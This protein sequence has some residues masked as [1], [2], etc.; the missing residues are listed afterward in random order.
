MIVLPTIGIYKP[1]N[2]PTSRTTRLVKR[3]A[4]FTILVGI[5]SISL[6]TRVTCLNTR[7]VSFLIYVIDQ[8][9]NE[10]KQKKEKLERTEQ[11][12]KQTNIKYEQTNQK[13][14]QYKKEMK[15]SQ[16]LNK[17]KLKINDTQNPF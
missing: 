9:F 6:V 11:E 3:F 16:R 17:Q 13:C 8:L 2:L 5:L 1:L 7:V 12:L 10:M 4:S 15:V 14:D